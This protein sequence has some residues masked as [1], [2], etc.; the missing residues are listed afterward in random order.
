MRPDVP[1]HVPLRSRTEH[2]GHQ[3]RLTSVQ[4]APLGHI[5]FRDATYY[6]INSYSATSAVGVDA[7]GRTCHPPR[8]TRQSAARC[9]IQHRLAM[10][11]PSRLLHVGH[12]VGNTGRGAQLSPH[13]GHSGT[14]HNTASHPVLQDLIGRDVAGIPSPWLGVCVCVCVC[15]AMAGTATW[16]AQWMLAA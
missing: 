10:S 6:H 12:T 16:V 3:T 7:T 8:L 5:P 13:G 9:M 1:H 15:V 4:H 11:M 14:R 2:C